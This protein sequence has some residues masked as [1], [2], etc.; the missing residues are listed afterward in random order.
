MR[1]VVWWADGWAA[2]IGW[3]DGQMDSL[4][5]KDLRVDTERDRKEKEIEREKPR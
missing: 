1:R 2:L 3:K 4:I 5:D